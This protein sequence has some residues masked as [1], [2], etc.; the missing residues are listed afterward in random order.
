MSQEYQELQARKRKWIPLACAGKCTIA[1]AA[2]EIGITARSVSR[3]KVR[4]HTVGANIFINGH[5]GKAY[6]R[7]KFS[8]KKRLEICSIY[9]THWGNTNFA[10]FRDRLEQY[11]NTK[12]ST[13][14]LTK[15]L[16]NNNIISPKWRGP[17]K[18][19]KKHLP[20]KERP[21]TG[22]LLQL[23][24]SEHDWLMNGEK[25]TLHG[26]VDDATHEPT[27]LYFCRNECRLGYSEVLRQTLTLQGKPEAVYID[28]HA[29]FVKNQRKDGKTQEE[30][31]AYSKEEQTHWTEICKEMKTDII[32][33][34]SPEAKG[35]IERF[36]ETLQGRL[37]PLLR[38]LGI[39]TIEKANA[40][41]PEYIKMYKDRFAVPPQDK[42][43]RFKPTNM[44][45]DELEKL[46]SVKFKK[47]TRW[48]GE[49]I[50]HGFLFHLE[51]ARA[52][53]QDFT[54]CL[55][56]KTGI[57]AF[58]NGKFYPVTLKEPLTDCA[59]D[60][61]PQVEKDLIARYLLKSTR[62]NTCSFG[63]AV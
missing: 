16:N 57:R 11:H 9:K 39:D 26:A 52:A 51:A 56:E 8:N 18:E 24:A 45:D 48:N 35:R 3:L 50:F 55:S 33:A 23:D 28:R 30:R 14:T 40:F 37:P 38:F 44:T 58:M 36:W 49:F 6:Q 7:K 46:L 63:V 10:T 13:P 21:C 60:P 32:L 62:D 2:K 43:S 20:R 31:L 15:I 5:T 47:R 61:M 22:E 29:A 12:I 1:Q 25:I 34:L 54:L 53:C 17:K 59:G 4:Y 41:M 42:K 19:K 27:G